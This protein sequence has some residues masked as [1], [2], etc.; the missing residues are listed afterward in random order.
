M[1]KLHFFVL[2][3][4]TIFTLVSCDNWLNV[5]QDPSNHIYYT[6][7]TLIY[8][9]SGEYIFI[10]DDNLKLVPTTK[11][12]IPEAQKD[13]LLNKRYYISFQ[14]KNQND[15][16]YSIN[17]LSMQMMT[18]NSIIEINHNDSIE[19]YKNELL[20]IK[21]IWISSN[22]LN[23]ITE[24]QGS[25]SILHNYNMLHN[26]NIQSD[27]LYLTLRYDNNGD[28]KTY[29]FQQ[30]IYYDINNYLTNQKDSTTICF[31]YNSGYL[32][33]NTLYLKTASK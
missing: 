21:N 8:D 5:E 14:I 20:N 33:Y 19:N 1:K 3:L 4:F 18:Q 29:S 30:A 2:S 15:K 26:P 12:T 6:A 28:A 9:P 22:Y 31:K 13:T 23:I 32:E 24:V 27:T 16:E 17:L 10:T 7:S 11:L 25:G